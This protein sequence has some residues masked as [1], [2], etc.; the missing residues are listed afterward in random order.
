MGFQGFRISIVQGCGGLR[1]RQR[2]GPTGG[3]RHLL[4][5]LFVS[6]RRPAPPRREA[7]VAAALAKQP[8][9]I[10]AYRL[11]ARLKDRASPF[12]LMTLSTKDL[13]LKSRNV[14]Q[15][16]APKGGGKSKK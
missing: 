2:N 7:K 10:A 16:K 6:S 8:E 1:R 5:P 15:G 3:L 13:K 14:P 9:L 12:D 4:T 11:K